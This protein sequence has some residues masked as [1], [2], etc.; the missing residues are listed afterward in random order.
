[1]LRYERFT[2]LRR[3]SRNACETGFAQDKPALF[4]RHDNAIRL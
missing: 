2:R 1:V 3:L 4:E